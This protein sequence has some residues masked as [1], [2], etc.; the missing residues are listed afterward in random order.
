MAPASPARVLTVTM[1]PGERNTT[2][3]SSKHHFTALPEALNQAQ[4]REMRHLKSAVMDSFLFPNAFIEQS[5]TFHSYR[6]RSCSC[7][8]Q[9]TTGQHEECSHSSVEA[10]QPR[11][12]SPGWTSGLRVTSRNQQLCGGGAFHQERAGS[13]CHQWGW[14]CQSCCVV[15]AMKFWLM[16]SGKCKREVSG[17]SCVESRG[18]YCCSDIAVPMSPPSALRGL[19]FTARRM[20]RA[21]LG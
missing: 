20:R 2:L 18:C 11:E 12:A 15:P 16:L 21:L 3:N 13:S 10:L 4:I 5:A 8:K 14:R 17:S 9:K 1:Q 7:P 6:M 19:Q